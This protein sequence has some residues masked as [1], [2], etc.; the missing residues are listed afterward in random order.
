MK[1]RGFRIE[2]GEIESV[3]ARQPEVA[4]AAVV[5]RGDPAGDGRLV[6]Y[7]VPARPIPFD[8]AR[9][10]KRL[11]ELLPAYLVPSAFVGIERLPLTGNGKLDRDALPDPGGQRPATGR[12]PRSETERGLCLLFAEVLGASSV[13]ID[14]DFFD[15]GG[16]SLLAIRLVNRIRT[17]LGLELAVGQLFDARTIADMAL[18]AVPASEGRPPLRRIRKGS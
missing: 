3:L 9:L 10:R 13:T 6:A 18:G 12:A 2:P 1:V 7:V 8:L 5:V 15:L 14:D 11:I 16:N 4:Q 17:E